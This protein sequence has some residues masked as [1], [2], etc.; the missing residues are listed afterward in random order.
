MKATTAH[1]LLGVE[2]GAASDDIVKAYRRL[3]AMVCRKQASSAI[4]EDLDD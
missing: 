3:A 2:A 4:S 1:E